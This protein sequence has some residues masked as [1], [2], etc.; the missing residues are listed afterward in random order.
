MNSSGTVY[1]SGQF[2]DSKLFENEY[3]ATGRPVT[4]A[5]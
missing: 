3:F 5:Y 2:V 1:E 4:E